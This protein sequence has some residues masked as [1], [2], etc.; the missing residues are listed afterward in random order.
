[1]ILMRTLV[2]ESRSR[3]HCAPSPS[4]YN[5]TGM[6]GNIVHFKQN[7]G[8]DGAILECGRR[9]QTGDPELSSIGHSLPDGICPGL[10][11]MRAEQEL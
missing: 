9:F 6:N 8:R 10:D 2:D 3:S 4:D 5:G 1:M 7:R 11:R